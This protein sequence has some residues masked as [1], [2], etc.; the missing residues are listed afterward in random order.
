MDSIGPLGLQNDTIQGNALR[1]LVIG[2]PLRSCPKSSLQQKIPAG[3]YPGLC[4]GA[5]ITIMHVIKI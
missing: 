2:Q 3:V 5:G 1:S 4:A